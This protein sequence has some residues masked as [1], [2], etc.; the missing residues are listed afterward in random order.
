MQRPDVEAI[1]APLKPFQRRTVD[2]AFHRL[3][4]APDSTSRFLVADE[5]GLGKTLVARGVIGRAI[6]HLWDDVDRIDIVYICSNA[7]IARANLPKLQVS[8][9][10]ERTF[11]L[12]TRLTMLATQLAPREGAPSL[13]DSKLNFVS[14]TPAT[15]FEMGNSGGQAK[16]RVVLFRLLEPLVERR[17]ALM[18]FLQGTVSHTERWRDRLRSADVPIDP[19]IQRRFEQA[20]RRSRRLRAELDEVLDT[21]FGRSRHVWPDEARRWRNRLIGEL[22]HL[23]AEVCVQALEPDLVILD[24]FQRFKSLLERNPEQRDPAAELAHALFRAQTPEGHPVRTLLLSATPYKLYTADAEIEHEDHYADFLATTQFLMDDDDTQV[25]AL[26]GQLSRFGSALKKAASGLPDQVITA[27]AVVETTLRAVMARTERVAASADRDAMVEEPKLAIQLGTS[28][29]QQYLAADALFAA[30]G[31]RDPIAFWKSAPY[32]MH[33]MRGYR[34]ND[35]LDETRVSAPEKLEKILREHAPAFLNVSDVLAWSSIDP[36][37]AK[38][39]ELSADLIGGG[40]WQLLWMPPTVPYWPLEGPFEGQEDRTKALLFSAWNVV[41]DVVSAVL[42]Y[43]AERRMMGGQLHSYQD[44]ARQRVPRLRLSQ[45]ATGARAR[46]RLFLLLLPCLPLADVAHPL[47]APLGVDRRDWVRQCVEAL[48]ADPRIPN[49]VEGEVDDRWEWAVPLV[50]DPGL[51]DFVETWRADEELPRP[52][53]ELFVD[54]V[55]D[56]LALD[57][58]TLGRRPDDLVEMLTE[59]ALAS[60]AIVAAR[61]AAMASVSDDT[62]RRIA[63]HIGEAF[64]RLFNRPAVIALLDQLDRDEENLGREESYYW[65]SVLRYCRE[66][67]LQAVLDESWHLMW[68][69]RAWSEHN[70]NDPIAWACA[71]DLAS[72]VN[73]TPSRVHAHFYRE[74]DA[75]QIEKDEVRLRT[76]FALRF[77]DIRTEEREVNQDMVRNVFNSPFRPFVLTSTSVGQEG[78]DFHPWCHRLVHWDLPGNPVDL[79]QREGRVHRYKGH[80]VRRNVAAAWMGEAIAQCGP[81]D[82]LWEIMFGIADRAARITAESDLV[83]LWIAPGKHRVQ[84]HVPLLPYSREVEMFHRLKRQ[85]AAYRVVFGQ[86]RQEEMMT[87]LDQSDLEVESLREWAIDLTPR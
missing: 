75:G 87:L 35:R 5:V 25:A 62:R 24:E 72:V 44:P 69:Q 15:S 39:R 32:L 14:F 9:A 37:N 60:P 10:G 54:Y 19:T 57:P 7:S 78:L 31:D 70:D 85:L 28:D 46:H 65:R 38:L 63:V 18:N 42:S 12:A 81:G 84:R 86:P 45:T 13:I 71:Q 34:F 26:K 79:E 22:R 76:V 3:F 6:D 52:N 33:F 68:E 30:V 59:V 27:K 61:A 73:P 55:D 83:P 43:E 66:G 80:A 41:P 8:A 58:A 53:P 1:L 50:L 17:T 29:I 48:L 2:H 16:E 77:G 74:N 36:G 49:P 11:A 20:F 82:D 40:L 56:L 64:W 51:K 4:E 21:W 67:N 23:L 47:G